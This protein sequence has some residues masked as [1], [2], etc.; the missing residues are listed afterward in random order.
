MLKPT[1]A[2][3]AALL[4]GALLVGCASPPRQS[5]TSPR[6]AP[7]TRAAKP[8]ESFGEESQLVI[9]LRE[10]QPSSLPIVWDIRKIALDKA[11]GNQVVVPRTEVTLATSD[12][13]QG[14][15]LVSVSDIAPGQYAGITIFTGAVSYEDTGSPVATE[16]GL[17]TVQHPFSIVGGNAKTLLLAADL[18]PPGADRAAFRFQPRVS[19]DDEPASFKGKLVY[20]SNELSSNVSVIDKTL[21]RVVKNV[22]MGTRPSAMAADLRRNRLYIAD[23][24]AGAIYEMDMISQHLLK[25]TQIEYVDEPVHIEPLPSK[26]LLIVVN[27]GTDTIHLVDAFTL[28]VTATITVGDGPVDAVYSPLWDLAFVVNLWDNTVSVIDFERQPA[29]VDTT[30]QVGQ[31]PSGITIDD[32]MGWLYVSNSGSTTLSVIKIETMAVERSVAVGIGA[33]DIALD[34]YGRRLFLSMTETDE[35]LCVDP[36]TGVMVY[37]VSLPGKPGRLMFDP[38]EKKLYVAVPTENGVAVI[39]TITRKIQNW[40][41]TGRGPSSIAMRL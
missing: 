24:R 28:S 33:G 16:A 34:P 22:Y 36:Y 40:I 1:H 10:S 20:V 2:K 9:Y 11:D 41:E 12:L 6:P 23:T 39:D 18:A 32:S 35:V 21:K 7:D 4:L 30:L 26:D 29:I 31:R 25:A 19:I 14:Q 27:S 38:D 15:R 17:T 37:S 8:V 5:G 13:D 3:W